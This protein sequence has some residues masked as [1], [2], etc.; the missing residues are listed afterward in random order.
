MS[1]PGLL[2][3]PYVPVSQIPVSTELFRILPCILGTRLTLRALTLL[4]VVECPPAHFHL[5]DPHTI[6][7]LYW[8]ELDTCHGIPSA[9]VENPTAFRLRRVFTS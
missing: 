3:V 7:E 4:P 9:S 8:I 5:P 6:A 1:S 2:V